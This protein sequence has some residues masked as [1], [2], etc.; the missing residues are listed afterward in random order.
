M[1]LLFL[2]TLELPFL[3][4]VE[5]TDFSAALCRPALRHPTPH[6]IKAHCVAPALSS[7]VR[8]ACKGRGLSSLSAK[9]YCTYTTEGLFY[10][11]TLSMGVLLLTLSIA[12]F[13]TQMLDICFSHSIF[14]LA[15][16]T[17]KF[18]LKSYEPPWPC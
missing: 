13:C 5:S 10:D 9:S 11:F 4:S 6:D 8:N 7:L 1:L 15:L 16:G 17:L 3:L 12:F 18:L 2:L 14:S